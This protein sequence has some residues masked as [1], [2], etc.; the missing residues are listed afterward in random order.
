MRTTFETLARTLATTLGMEDVDIVDDSAT[1]AMDGYLV[2]MALLP[3]AEQVLLSTVVA[4]LSAATPREALYGTL[5]RGQHFFAHTQGATLSM[6]DAGRYIV[7]Q[8]VDALRALDVTAYPVLV[9]R[10]MQIADIWRERC[11]RMEA[12][13]ALGQEGQDGQAANPGFPH[14]A[15]LKA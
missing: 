5:L 11:T 3:Q 6:D 10:F 7:L 12:E 4:E 15:Y 1:F 13:A 9:D 2:L 14:A 8:R